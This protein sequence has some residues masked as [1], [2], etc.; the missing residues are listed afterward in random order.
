VR[1]THAKANSISSVF[2]PN[3]PKNQHFQFMSL[4][5]T[6]ACCIVLNPDDSTHWQAALQAPMLFRYLDGFINQ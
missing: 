1:R 3:R 6:H 4:H 2:A 5:S